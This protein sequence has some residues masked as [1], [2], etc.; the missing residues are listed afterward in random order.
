MTGTKTNF[1]Q[2]S[3]TVKM[4]AS[5]TQET[6]SCAMVYST[7]NL[8][9]APATADKRDGMLKMKN[10]ECMAQAKLRRAI[11]RVLGP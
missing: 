2:I 3:L 4:E 10:L 5:S 11:R 6:S 7:T 8:S 9:I 1:A